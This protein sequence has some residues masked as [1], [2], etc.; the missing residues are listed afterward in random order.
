MD[1]VQAARFL[2]DLR[3]ALERPGILLG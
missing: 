1:G 2:D 3:M